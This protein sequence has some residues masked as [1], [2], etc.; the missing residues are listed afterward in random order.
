V[1]ELDDDAEVLIWLTVAC[2]I[3]LVCGFFI[4]KWYGERPYQYGCAPEVL[5][6]YTDG[7]KDCKE[8]K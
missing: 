8:G 2:V 6:A 4:G 7:F 3:V 1:D 5:T